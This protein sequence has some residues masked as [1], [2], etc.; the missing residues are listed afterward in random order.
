MTE[1][2]KKGRQT[3]RTEESAVTE[4]IIPQNNHVQT[5]SRGTNKVNVELYITVLS[6]KK[7]ELW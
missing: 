4:V 3:D 2:K 7:N 1:G 5:I 6:Y